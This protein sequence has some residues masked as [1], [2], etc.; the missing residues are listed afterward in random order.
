MPVLFYS[1]TILPHYGEVIMADQKTPVTLHLA[2]DQ[3]VSSTQDPM[4]KKYSKEEPIPFEDFM[5]IRSKLNS[6]HQEVNRLKDEVRSLTPLSYRQY[7]ATNCKDKL[8]QVSIK[9]MAGIACELSQK[10]YETLSELNVK[11]LAVH[12]QQPPRHD[13]GNV[14]ICN[15]TCSTDD[16]TC[17]GYG[18][19]NP[20]MLHGIIHP[21]ILT[22]AATAQAMGM[23]LSMLVHINDNTVNV[24]TDTPA[25]QMTIEAK[26][27]KHKK[28]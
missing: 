15:V 21:K 13:N 4:F 11:N 1:S 9:D 2:D 18:I 3:K 5:E 26:T 28:K 19:T 16:K 20:D 24:S 6:K 8:A 27:S 14:A 12:V 17:T 25:A 23:A 10:S 22:D 7:S